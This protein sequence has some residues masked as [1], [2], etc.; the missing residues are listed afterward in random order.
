VECS[1]DQC[2]QRRTELDNELKLL[3]RELK[4]RDEDVR[5]L[6]LKTQVNASLMWF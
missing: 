5:Q 3:R 1:S 2:K 6:E 4:V